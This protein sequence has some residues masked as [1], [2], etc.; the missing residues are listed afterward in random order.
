MRRALIL[1]H[2]LL[3][4]VGLGLV[5]HGALDLALLGAEEAGLRR[6]MGS[7]RA[8]A[9]DLRLQL[10][11]AT[12]ALEQVAVPTQLIAANQRLELGLVPGTSTPAQR[13]V[14][15]RTPASSDSDRSAQPTVVAGR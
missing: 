13:G 3:V 6:R 1:L 8:A 14:A 2:L 5:L 12:A 10:D 15:T 4:A 11:R 9:V 7:D